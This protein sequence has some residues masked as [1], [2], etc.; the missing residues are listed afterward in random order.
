MER[1]AKER[2]KDEKQ[3]QRIPKGEIE[4]QRWRSFCF[5]KVGPERLYGRAGRLLWNGKQEREAS[6]RSITLFPLLVEHSISPHVVPVSAFE[7]LLA[8][9]GGKRLAGR[10]D[11]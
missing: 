3:T 9:L 11:S 6:T 10:H 2:M 1:V 5:G 7:L 4:E 8:G